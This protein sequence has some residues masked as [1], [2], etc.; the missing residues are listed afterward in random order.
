MLESKV[1]LNWNLWVDCP[2]CGETMNLA[3]VDE[4]GIY[5]SPIFNNQWD[6]LQGEEIKCIECGKVFTIE[7]VEC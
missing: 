5:S 4:D 7:C 6:D 1:I 2:H 3:D